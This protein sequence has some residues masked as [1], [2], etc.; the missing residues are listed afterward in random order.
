MAYKGG[1]MFRLP[2]GRT[3]S[4]TARVFISAGRIVLIV[5]AML[6]L[7]NRSPTC[8][9]KKPRP[10]TLEE[11]AQTW[12][13]ISEDELYLV[14]MSLNRD[15]TGQGAYVF[16]DEP[17]MVFRVVSWKYDQKSIEIVVLPQ[18]S[19]KGFLESGHMSGSVMGYAMTLGISGHRWKLKLNMRPEAVFERRWE[20]TKSAM[21]SLSL[22]SV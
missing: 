21:T 11:I 9:D 20:E 17:P 8:A 3:L 19:G 6:L 14:R 2:L 4:Q 15:G 10:L 18:E 7:A 12:V 16:Q 13:G 1:E 5:F 22:R